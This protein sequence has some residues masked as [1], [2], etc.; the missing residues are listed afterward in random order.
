M[1]T[2]REQSMSFLERNA[3]RSSNPLAD[4]NEDAKFLQRRYKHIRTNEPRVWERPLSN[5][6]KT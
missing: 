5:P 2:T 1:C 6:Q 3:R 4:L